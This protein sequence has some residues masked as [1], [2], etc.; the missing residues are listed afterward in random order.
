MS[1]RNSNFS[2][3]AFLSL[4]ELFLSINIYAQPAKMPA[5]AKVYG[6][7]IDAST[8]K[9]LE[10]ATVSVFNVRDSLLGGALVKSNGDFEIDKLPFGP[11]KV[12]IQFIG[13]EPITQQVILKPGNVAF[14]MGNI[15][16]EVNAK[17][18]K[19]VVIEGEKSN[20]ILGIDRRIYNVDKDLGA[21]GGTAIDAMK[22]IPGVTVN[23]DG[24]VQLRN[25]SPIIFVDGR[26]TLLTLD[27]IPTEDI[28][29]IEVITNPS[30]KYVADATGGILNVVLKK[31]LKPGYNGS[32]TGSVGTN[33]RYSLNG[34]LNVRD[35][36]FNV[37]MAYNVYTVSN[38]NDGFSNRINLSENEVTGFVDLDNLSLTTRSGQSGRLNV[39]YKINNRS[40]ISMMQNYSTNG[41]R[42]DEAQNFDFL[43]AVR[44]PILIGNRLNE[45][46]T[47]WDTYNAQIMFVHN[48]PKQGKELTSDF[49]FISSVSENNSLFSTRN[50]QPNGTI[51]PNQPELQ[52][53][54]GYRTADFGIWQLDFVNPISDTTKL[55][56]GA[57]AAYKVSNSE[58]RVFNFD[59][60]LNEFAFDSTLSNAFRIDDL[61][62]AAYVNYSSMWGKIAY[63]AGLRFEQT[64]FVGQMTDRE[65]RFE[66]I[67]PRGLS[68]FDKALFPSLY[69]SRKFDKKGEVQLNFSRKIGRPGFMQ[70][71]PFIMYADR[72]SVQIG[73]PVLAPEFIN[74]AEINYSKIMEKSNFLTSLYLRYTT[75]K[76]T[77]FYF[78]SPDDPE[79]LIGTYI[80][81]TSSMNYG[82]ENTYKYTPSKM[83]DF[84]LN[85]HVF[86]TDIRAEQ[87]NQLIANQGWSWNAKVIYSLR[88]PKQWSIQ[89]NGSYEAPRFIPQGRMREIYYADLSINKN[90]NKHFNASFTISD[91]FN[92]KRFGTFYEDQFFIQDLSRRWEVRYARI[93]LVWKFGEP[94][95]SFFRRKGGQRGEPGSGGTE[96]QEM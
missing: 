96:M 28:D 79:V 41:F 17:V 81:G 37:T 16:L 29:R 2:F 27:Q 67:Y 46:R 3:I 21:R 25:S 40:T 5:I 80:N 50:F 7:V 55:E 52:D 56:L 68:N 45:Q 88:L 92:T 10:F 62:T 83:M 14:D 61:V 38:D 63:Q 78:P 4:F 1:L 75:D 85:T 36:K 59:H 13:F 93:N 87:N 95:F 76:I 42:A 73:N 24:S 34:L 26:P 35:G 8:K 19:E 64:Y 70:L 74:L 15:K 30:A 6:K 49:S 12:K 60:G 90:F 32:I 77:N 44:N 94:D 53:N 89:L 33:D 54:S 20:V 18:L 71:I 9:P 72:Q 91:M 48:F 65:G 11:A 23:S 51:F 86:Y 58:F 57:R 66:F 82:W 69:F 47:R 84:T 22:S 39:S 43:D 31:N